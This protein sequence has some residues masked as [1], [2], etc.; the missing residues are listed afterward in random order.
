MQGV[1]ERHR[2]FGERYI[3][4]VNRYIPVCDLDVALRE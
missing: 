2:P 3:P 4:I 1:P